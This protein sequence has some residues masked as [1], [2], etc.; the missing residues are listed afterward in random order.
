MI[1]LTRKQIH[2]I[3]ST[4]RQALGIT[5]ARRAPNVTV[6]ATPIGLLIQSA[7][8][9]VAIEHRVEGDFQ[10]EVVTLPY[11]ALQACEGKRNDQ[12]SIQRDGDTISVEWLDGGIPQTAQYSHVDPIEVPE[13]PTELTGIDREFIQA[14]AEVVATTDNESSRYALSCVRLRGSDGQIA[15]TDGRQ[16]LMQSGFSFPWDDDILVPA[17][18]A[19]SSKAF[20]NAT[21][22]S[23]GHSDD[24]GS[25]QAD[26]WTLHLKIEKDARFPNVDDQVPA[27]ESATTT[28]T[29]SDT[30]AEFLTQASQKLPAASEFNAPVTVD[31]NGSVVIR[32]K[33][34]D[35]DVG[36]ELVL[37]NSQRLGEEVRFNT[38]RDYLRRAASLG[39]R[40]IQ[41]RTSEA[42][43]FCRDDRRSYIW[44][45]L[46]KEG[47]IT[48]DAKLTRIESPCDSPKPSP[49]RRTT[50][51]MP[52]TKHPERTRPSEDKP[53][54]VLAKAEALRDSLSTALTDT[55]E[56]IAAIKAKRKQNR[57]VE[58]TL[59]SL[60]QLENIG[61]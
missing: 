18:K 40:Q 56:L 45:L 51:P 8:D 36:T 54:S 57:L 38:N 44:A 20:G 9:N 14:M 11:E 16:A 1:E 31:L 25:I 39:F 60:K 30:D 15:A 3:R 43:A 52:N 17:T 10:P 2:F 13:S 27:V 28:M 61:A 53:A 26:N 49:Q 24:W 34:A 37:S 23:I 58:T 12:V 6:R 29:L 42:P 32:A 22:V 35:Q 21:E 19:F 55:R 48:P 7:S 4:I 5:S 50:I 59:R 46:G 47:A 33:G 41:L